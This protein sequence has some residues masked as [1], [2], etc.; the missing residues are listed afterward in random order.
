MPPIACPIIDSY[1]HNN[2]ALQL[3]HKRPMMSSKTQTFDPNGD[4]VLVFNQTSETKTLA[5]VNMLV[6][7]KHMILASPVFAAMLKVEFKEGSTL[8]SKG[9]A[10]I[11]LPDDDP[12][13]SIILLNIIHGRPKKVPRRID[14]LLL[15]KLA[16][17]VDKYQMQEVVAVF[18]EIWIGIL[19]DTIPK[20]S[21][22]D[23][24]SW[25]CISWVFEDDP[26]FKRVTKVLM[27]ASDSAL[28]PDLVDEL[29][30]PTAVFGR[31][32]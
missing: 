20:A 5:Q 22:T 24:L 6:S 28:D 9:H 31:F 26:V 12:Q 4:V 17:L 3:K 8:E 13:A 30:I 1:Q 32:L 11:L 14:L 19:K 27:Q 18:S 21:T 15:Q 10:E 16:I 29:P 2:L 7:S 25:V 23:L